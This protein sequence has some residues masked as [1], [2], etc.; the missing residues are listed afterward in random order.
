MV[1]ETAWCVFG[2]PFSADVVLWDHSAAQRPRSRG[3]LLSLQSCLG[4]LKAILG[5]LKYDFSIF[6]AS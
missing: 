6:M 5:T 1:M 3:R 4:F 2:F